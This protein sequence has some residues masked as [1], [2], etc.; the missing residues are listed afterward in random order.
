MW[1]GREKL[2]K[3]I[4]L[5]SK[6]L[7]KQDR[8]KLR[9]KISENG[10]ENDILNGQ[11]VNAK[12]DQGHKSKSLSVKRRK[13][14]HLGQ[15]SGSSSTNERNDSSSENEDAQ[16]SYELSVTSPN[17]TSSESDMSIWC[18]PIGSDTDSTSSEK[19]PP[20]AVNSN[21][22]V[23]EPVSSGNIN[24]SIQTKSL[25]NTSEIKIGES[26]LSADRTSEA[27]E[28]GAQ[29]ISIETDSL[30]STENTENSTNAVP[31][32]PSAKKINSTQAP[33]P[34]KTPG[35]QKSP[36]TSSTISPRNIS[37]EDI[38][39]MKKL[40]VLIVT[41][42]SLLQYFDKNKCLTYEKRKEITKIV[43]DFELAED[44]SKRIAP[45]RFSFLAEVICQMFTSEN[46]YTF[47]VPYAR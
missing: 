21:S 27:K 18:R 39:S 5:T 4:S 35:T 13:K 46:P 43:I 20:G 37:S 40:F 38:S 41:G 3:K 42:R 10:R 29:S 12:N 36:L 16:N 26:I 23:V 11:K 45:E 34:P 32:M 9:K 14:A 19:P 25:P 7:E 30:K 47:Y 2:V 28:N 44:Q 24:F 1:S 6:P 22:S 17:Q 15:K 8:T 33:V 31:K